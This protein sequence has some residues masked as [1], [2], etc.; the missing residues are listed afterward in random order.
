M[1]LWLERLLF[2]ML[3]CLIPHFCRCCCFKR[4]QCKLTSQNANWLKSCSILMISYVNLSICQLLLMKFFFFFFLL[5]LIA[6]WTVVGMDYIRIWIQLWNSCSF[7]CCSIIKLLTILQI[8]FDGVNFFNGRFQITITSAQCN[9][10]FFVMYVC[11]CVFVC[12]QKINCIKTPLKK[13]KIN[14]QL[15]CLSAIRRREKLNY[16]YN[17]I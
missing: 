1:T 4:L 13:K 16:C 2:Q 7:V 6:N 8:D 14:T 15:K 3:W 10:F 17:F 11:V 12:V 9:S 5:M